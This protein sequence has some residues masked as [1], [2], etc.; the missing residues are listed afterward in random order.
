M[1]PWFYW[2]VGAVL[3]ILLE[4]VFSGFVLL[5]FGFAAFATSILS[6]LGIGIE[7]QILSF[8]F[9]TI[10]SF[11]T[12]RPF[13]LKHMKPKE[14]IVETNVYALIGHE[15]I[16][17]EE[18]DPSKNNGRVKIRGEEWGALSQDSTVIPIGSKV[19][20]VENSGNKLII[21]LYSK[22]E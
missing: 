15:A 2:L 17:V 16:V 4:L 7:L 12:V 21:K 3:L 10:V 6:L 22:G 11:V 19:K 5:S 18:I 20:V 14:G 9:F 1:N 8:I 13:F